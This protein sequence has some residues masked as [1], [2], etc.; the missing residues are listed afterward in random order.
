VDYGYEGRVLLAVPVQIPAD[1]KPAASQAL[2]ASISYLVCREVC[3]PAKAHPIL[4]MPAAAAGE[5]DRKALFAAARNAWPKPMP[6]GWMAR[7][8]DAGDH[9]VLSIETGMK[10][11]QA[12]FFPRDEDVVDNVAPQTVA[13]TDKGVNITLRK[14]DLLTKP[15]PALKGVVVLASG[16]AVEI[17]APVSRH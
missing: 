4:T 3:I 9:F 8:T 12:S 14:S 10:E 5:A 16:R 7:A 1:Y 15:I 13:P 6:A 11:T 2:G 17:S